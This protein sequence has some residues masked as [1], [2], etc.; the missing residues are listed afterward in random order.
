MDVVPILSTII[1]I[2]TIITLIV[3]VASYMTFRVKEKRKQEAMAK[4]SDV[5]SEDMKALMENDDGVT[6]VDHPQA[7]TAPSAAVGSAPQPAP[8]QTATT[9]I[10]AGASYA[11]QP[12]SAPPQPVM[13]QNNEQYPQ[14]QYAEPSTP[15]PAYSSAQAAFM[16]GF[17]GQTPPMPPPQSGESQA[18]TMR[19][20][21]L[22][23][24]RPARKDSPEGR[25]DETPV[26]K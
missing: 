25:R 21:T 20:F 24:A 12:Q 11:V 3:A 10:V 23:E 6:I 19:R 18:P 22:P 9:P 8:T 2:S 5:L 17:G 4:F 16:K 15:D 26:W 1:L 7:G 14:P 13:G